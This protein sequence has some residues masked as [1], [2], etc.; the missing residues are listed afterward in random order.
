MFAIL[1]SP[2]AR[3]FCLLGTV[4]IFAADISPLAAEEKPPRVAIPAELPDHPRLF[5]NNEEIAAFKA[6]VA[7]TPWLS[8]YLDKLAAEMEPAIADPVLP[9]ADK[10][11]NVEIAQTAHKLAILYVLRDEDR[12]AEPVAQI[13]QRYVEVFPQYE[14]AHLKG[15]ATGS[16]L[17]E[18]DWAINIASAYD[19]IY[20]AGVLSDEDKEAIEQQVFQPSAE[21]MRICNHKFRSNWRGR[22]IA[23]V[24]VLG[25]C[26]GDRELIDEAIN[27]YYEDGRLARDGFVQ[28][29]AWSI[30]ADGVFYERSM[31]YHMYTADAY[32]LIAET[33][34]H[35][36]ID[37][38]NLEIPGHRLDAGADPQRRFG[39][40]GRK[41]VKAIFD[42]P[43]YEAFSDGSLVRLGNSYTDRLERTRCYE[44]AWAAY[45]DP[46]Y[47]WLLRRPVAFYRPIAGG[48]YI[49][50]ANVAAAYRARPPQEGDVDVRRP[51]NPMEL[52]WLA[53]DLPQGEFDHTAD[54]RIGVTGRHENACTLLPNGGITVLR[55]SGDRDAVGVQM[56]YGDWGS[57]HTHPELLAITVAAEGRQIIPEV[58]YHH[59]GHEAF[60]T[61]DRQT[62]A[63]N[64]VTVDETSQYPQ[65][66]SDDPWAVERGKQ[67]HGEP[68]FFHAGNELKAFRATC[69]AAYDGVLLDRTIALL[70]EV[71]VDFYR[72]RSDEDHQYDFALHVDGRL[73]TSSIGLSDPTPGPV[74]S[75]LGYAHLKQPRRARL[76]NEPVELTYTGSDDGETSLRLRLLSPGATELISAKGHADL[77]ERTKD[78]LILRKQGRDVD[79]VNVIGAAATARAGYQARRLDDTPAGVLG[80]ELLREGEPALLV[81]SAEKS[82]DL[83]YGG[84]AVKGQLALLRREADGVL[85]V[86][87]FVP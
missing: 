13:L 79:F 8:E 43:F 9:R 24:A 68:V 50:P 7:R 55:Q 16:T 53:P 34:R 86:L 14:M 48:G 57:S 12:F 3:L 62:I 78:V 76:E 51:L 39:P 82:G 74:S 31:H 11:D 69:T 73:D 15:K 22:A 25:F 4:L 49:D 27:G 71:V 56:T 63:H 23:G 81:L 6:W 64:T 35:S 84:A 72:C 87:A 83:R 17:G 44:R 80:V 5:W 61:W 58:R 21:V 60:L 20:H 42:S 46:K 41:T 66:A 85:K 52:I 40:T 1:S 26:I 45:R 33:A 77:K 67:A 28:H 10:R 65:D 47:A 18:C 2:R 75:A 38:W 37:L 32:T 59:Y 30:L 19:L 54:A 70:D 36:G 29:V